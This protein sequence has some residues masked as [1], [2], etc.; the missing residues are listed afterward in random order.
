M[1]TRK[2]TIRTQADAY[3]VQVVVDGRLDVSDGFTSFNIT[4][5]PGEQPT[6]TA[7]LRAEQ[8][9]IGGQMVWFIDQRS[10]DILIALGWTPPATPNVVPVA[11]A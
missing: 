4:C 1:T 8:V 9:D 11:E 5:A 7:T 2:A 6:L 3:T 10:T